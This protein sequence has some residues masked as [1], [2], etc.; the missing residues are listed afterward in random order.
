MRT[1]PPANIRNRFAKLRRMVIN[2]FHSN[3]LRIRQPAASCPLQGLLVPFHLRNKT[4]R[5]ARLA[6]KQSRD[7]GAAINAVVN[8]V[9]ES[10][11]RSPGTSA[12]AEGQELEIVQ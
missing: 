12:H 10:G 6:A 9:P 7:N 8:L 4:T 5:D 3:E 11:V 1:I 2:G